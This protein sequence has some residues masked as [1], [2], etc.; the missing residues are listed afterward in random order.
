MG[1]GDGIGISV[2]D[3]GSITTREYKHKLSPDQDG[4]APAATRI[5]RKT[6]RCR[7]FDYFLKVLSGMFGVLG[8][9]SLENTKV[10]KY[11]FR[12]FDRY[13]IHIQ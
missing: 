8:I 6:A 13:E 5:M 2:R 11:P 9:P 4:M 3:T 12:V 7:K 1:L 10:T